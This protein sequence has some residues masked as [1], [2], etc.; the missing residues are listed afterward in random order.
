MKYKVLFMSKHTYF[1]SPL[2]RRQVNDSIFHNGKSIKLF[3]TS[4]ECYII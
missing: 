3:I 4:T 1:Y 2:L